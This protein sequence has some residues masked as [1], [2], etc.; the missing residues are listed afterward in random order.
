M[1]PDSLKPA[2]GQLIAASGGSTTDFSLLPIAVSGNNRVFA[3]TAGGVKQV[4]KWYFH[5]PADLRDRLGAEFAFS[6][7]AWDNGLRSTPRPIAKDPGH[8]LALYEFVEGERL[9][10]EQVDASAVRQASGFL[11][12][13]NTAASRA[14]AQALPMASEACFSV[15]AHAAMVDARLKRFDG[16]QPESDADHAAVDFVGELRGR[17]AAIRQA[18]DAGCRS[19]GLDP[20]AELPQS[21]RC[22]SPSDFGFHNALVRPGGA[23]CFLDFEYAGWDDPAKAIGDFFAHPGVPVPREHFDRF[24]ADVLAPFSEPEA[25][26]AR[27]RL[28]EPVFQVKWCCIILNEFLPV[29]ARR[30]RFADP[31]DDAGRRKQR[32]LLKARHLYRSIAH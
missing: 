31:E 2:I 16:L 8:H 11:A 5:D 15:A 28:L 27:A 26:A 30:R 25:M 19:L 1:V 4:L 20:A 13:L 21:Q 9:L 29:G 3:L 14:S 23:F 6:R 12:S 18:L 10:P 17:W 7:H 24:V 32:Q 22:L